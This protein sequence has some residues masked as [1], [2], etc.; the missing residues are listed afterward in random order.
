MLMSTPI[1]D[2]ASMLVSILAIL[3]LTNVAYV[4]S[5]P[6]IY[7]AMC[8]GTSYAR[9]HPVVSDFNAVCTAMVRSNEWAQDNVN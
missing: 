6:L 7:T 8:S 2:L 3:Q 5:R 4:S 9:S 1:T